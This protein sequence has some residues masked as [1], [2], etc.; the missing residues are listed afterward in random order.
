MKKNKK[1]LIVV[2][3]SPFL[4]IAIF[5]GRDIYRLGMAVWNSPLALQVKWEGAVNDKNFRDIGASANE[6]L[7]ESVF[8]E[9]LAFRS[10][11]WFSGWACDAVGSP[12]AIFSLNYRPERQERYFCTYK[13]QVT[14]GKVFNQSEQL[15]DLEFMR[16]WIPEKQADF[17]GFFQESFK[18]IAAGKR[19][20]VHCDAGRDRTG[21]YAA[22]LIALTAE[23]NGQLDNRMLKV[24]ECDYR[25]TKSLAEEKFGRMEDFISEITS[26]QKVLDFLSQRCQIP[27]ADLIAVAEKMW[28]AKKVS[29]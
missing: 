24:I 16:T 12:E 11:V 17:C 19:T 13:D 27:Q 28:N 7:G 3:L 25:K 26:E 2:L 23:L 22:L 15:Y 4:L 9:G 29:S 5:F 10:N 20:L 1:T 18:S 21:T 6:C 14:I 8:K